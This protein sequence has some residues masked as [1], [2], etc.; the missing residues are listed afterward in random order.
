M[1]RVNYNSKD[2]RIYLDGM[3]AAIRIRYR[4]ANIEF[5]RVF[6]VAAQ[7]FVD[8]MGEDYSVTKPRW[9]LSYE[10]WFWSV[11]YRGQRA[12]AAMHLH[13]AQYHASRLSDAIEN[14]CRIA[15]MR[16]TAEPIEVQESMAPSTSLEAGDA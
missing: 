5:R 9:S 1:S 4:N 15:A 10:G 2:M 8:D 16:W 12:K 13:D 3:R 7:R 11:I 6:K 14:S